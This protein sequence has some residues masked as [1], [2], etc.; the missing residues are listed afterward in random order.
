MN[1]TRRTFI[2]TTAAAASTLL[3]PKII[4]S[5]PREK[6]IGLQLYTVRDAMKK[7]IPGTIAKIASIGYNTVEAAGYSE[8][9]FYGMEPLEFK[10]L[11]EDNGMKVTSSHVMFEEVESGRAIDAHKKLGVDYLIF[12][13]FP[14]R[15]HEAEDDYKQAAAILNRTG[16]LC[17]EA[18]IRFG[19]HNHAYEFELFGDQTGYEI[20]LQNT[21]ADNVTFQLDLYWAVFAKQNPVDL[22][23]KFPSSFELWHIKDM[24][25]G[26]EPTFTEVGT[27]IIDF[28]DIFDEKKTSGMKAFFIEQDICTIDPLESIRISYDNLNKLNF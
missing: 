14:F 5:M 19:Y 1:Q 18:R 23:Y 27:G 13:V 28:Q 16:E 20:L 9:K 4:Y 24:T 26:T 11:V 15:V 22:F 25:A 10:N 2:K 3:L 21:I 12:P 7:D 8:G 17:N 6:K